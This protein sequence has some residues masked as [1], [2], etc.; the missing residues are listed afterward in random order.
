MDFQRTGLYHHLQA[1][2]PRGAASPDA[3]ASL[4][5]LPASGVVKHLSLHAPG[6]L[7]A[8]S[9]TRSF[10]ARGQSSTRHKLDAVDARRIIPHSPPVSA[11]ARSSAPRQCIDDEACP[12]AGPASDAVR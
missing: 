10:P 7:L 8:M 2:R 5:R 11:S 12:P 3:Y 4:E 6:W 9:R 1:Q